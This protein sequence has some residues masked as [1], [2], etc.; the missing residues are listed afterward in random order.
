M[1]NNNSLALAQTAGGAC[2]GYQ[3]IKHGL[4][5]T[6]GIRIEYHTTNNKNAAAI[7]QA[8]NFL[9][10]AFGGINGC[11]GRVN[12][13][14]FVENSKNFIHITGMNPDG[15][16]DKMHKIIQRFLMKPA[17]TIYRKVQCCLY[18]TVGNFEQQE[19]NQIKNKNNFQKA[20]WYTKKIASAFLNNKTTKFCIPGIDSYFNSEFVPDNNDIALKS[21]KKVKVYNNRFSAMLAGL[22]QFGIKGIK[23]NKSRAAFGL[24]TLSLG[25]YSGAKL[26]DKGL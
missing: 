3:G 19:I 17:A 24:A 7:K 2:L 6:L 23:E 21:S 9:D 15:H 13:E 18:Q 25:L 8:G 1:D 10:P 20:F 26:I 11:S 12:N 22:E 4:P 5:R 16:K 14:G